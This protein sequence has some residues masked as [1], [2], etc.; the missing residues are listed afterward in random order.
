MMHKSSLYTSTTETVIYYLYSNIFSSRTTLNS[1]LDSSKAPTNPSHCKW[2]TVQEHYGAGKY[3][4][5]LKLTPA[6][7]VLFLFDKKISRLSVTFVDTR[8]LSKRS[9]DKNNFWL[10]CEK[11]IDG[12]CANVPTAS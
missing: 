7:W 6:V 11:D 10:S 3:I 8:F 12:E 9:H 5:S 1:F 4:H 2:S